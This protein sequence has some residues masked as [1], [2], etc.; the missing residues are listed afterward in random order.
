MTSPHQKK[1]LALHD[2]SGFGRSS[3]VPIISTLSVMGHQ[4]VPLPTAVFSTH[5]AISGYIVRD[6]TEDLLPSIAQ[7][8][9]LALQFDAIYSG[10]VGSEQ[11]I[12]C[13]SQAIH[14]LRTSNSLVLVDPVMGDNG[15]I[16]ETYTTQMCNGMQD[17]CALADIITPNLT[18][19]AILLGYTPTDA[20]HSPAETAQW[21]RTLEQRYQA[22]VVLTG[23]SGGSDTVGVLCC[24]KGQLAFFE[25]TR[26][27]EYYP[28]TGDLFASVLLGDLLRGTPLPDACKTA[29]HFVRDC[30]RETAALQTNHMHGVQFESLLGNLLPHC[31]TAQT[32]S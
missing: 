12:H 17:L 18:E 4:C 22:K 26:I 15:A 7:Y 3:L 20:P 19:A 23:V 21:A 27:A 28:G 25:H 9:Q 13:I 32:T 1:I 24:E 8:E 31:A 11:Q 30:I 10:F 14:R 5:T 2:L 16:Y 29:A 6:L